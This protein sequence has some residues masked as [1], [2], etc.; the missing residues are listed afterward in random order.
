MD[1]LDYEGLKRYNELLHNEIHDNELVV[2]AALNEIKER[3]EILSHEYVDLGL[4]SGTLWATCNVGASSPTDYGNYYMYGMG[5]KT[6]DVSDTPYQGME[7]PL[8][9]EYD[10]AAQV[11]GEGWRMPTYTQFDELQNNTTC[12]WVTNYQGSGINGG[13]VTGPNGNTIFL[14]AAG[15]YYDDSPGDVNSYASF[16]TS[17]PSN[18][19]EGYIRYFSQ[20][21]GWEEDSYN[22]AYGFP[23]R[24]VHD[25]FPVSPAKV[26]DSLGI[27]SSTGSATK[28]LNEKGNFVSIPEA[29]NITNGLLSKNTF[30]F[31]MNLADTLDSSDGSIIMSTANGFVSAEPGTDYQAPLTF[32]TAPSSS[33]KVA[34]M[35]E[36]SDYLPLSGGTMSGTIYLGAN[37]GI[38]GLGG[39]GMLV[40]APIEG[41]TGVAS[42]DWAVGSANYRGL[43]RSNSSLRLYD[44][45]NYYD[46]CDSSNVKNIINNYTHPTA[47][48]SYTIS[49]NVEY[50]LDTITA[51]TTFTLDNPDG[52]VVNEYKF[53]FDMGSTAYSV[54]MP[55]TVIWASEPTFEA[56]NHYEV[57]I[58]YD[59]IGNKYYGLCTAFCNITLA[60]R[61][62]STNGIDSGTPW[63]IAGTYSDGAN[64]TIT[65]PIIQRSSNNLKMCG[66][67]SSYTIAYYDVKT[68][69]VKTKTYT[70][71]N[72]STVYSTILSSICIGIN[73]KLGTNYGTN[74]SPANVPSSVTYY[75]EL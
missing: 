21:D 70:S 35:A 4:P 68:A 26:K 67:G 22:R 24:P 65:N 34:T 58:K 56:K 29:S 7:D 2:A 61:L 13:L 1:Y 19:R 38:E 17:S 25:P 23:V 40:C 66:S 32:N 51:N 64:G 63:V 8:P 74:T 15:Y 28:Y 14:P 42:S 52:S 5:A 9:E 48:T 73:N 3:V 53:Q 31:L 57:S 18:T 27:N 62:T 71:S 20:Y 44:G 10:T 6:Y 50:F 47:A 43:F 36:L 30:S 60:D 69:T 41:W 75:I 45:T 39:A 55:S 11:W 12:Q 54:K 59:P 37:I 49:P 16:W 46:I 72:Y 33:N